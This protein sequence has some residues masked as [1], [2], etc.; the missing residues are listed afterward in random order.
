MGSLWPLPAHF[1]GKT[2]GG[3]GGVK[4]PRLTRCG[5]RPDRNL[6]VRRALILILPIRCY[7]VT[8]PRAA[9]AFRSAEETS[10]TCGAR[11]PDPW[12]LMLIRL[13]KRWEQECSRKGSRPW[14]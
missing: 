10:F 2:G 1:G 14:A 12:E 6:A 3:G 5:H 8:C 4:V 11:S 13:A 7:A 9:H